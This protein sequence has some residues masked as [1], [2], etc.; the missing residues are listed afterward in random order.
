MH[1]IF[2]Y[3]EYECN[4]QYMSPN[5]HHVVLLDI[6]DLA[7][8]TLAWLSVARLTT[9]HYMYMYMPL[10]VH[11]VVPSSSNC[12]PVCTY[13]RADIHVH[14]CTNT[15]DRSHGSEI[16]TFLIVTLRNS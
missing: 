4:N 12:S 11:V 15:S 2:V 3:Q 9:Y 6:C 10:C 14:V 5:P 1:M 13:C 16:T 8:S 7:K